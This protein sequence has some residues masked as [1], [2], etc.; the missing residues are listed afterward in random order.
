MD[1]ILVRAI[2]K[3]GSRHRQK[4]VETLVKG[5]GMKHGLAVSLKSRIVNYKNGVSGPTAHQ[6][7][8]E[9]QEDIGGGS[10]N[11]QR[12]VVNFVKVL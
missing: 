7:V 9:V 1:R 10:L 11:R 6:L 4:E 3:E 2:G 12:T 8:E 5:T